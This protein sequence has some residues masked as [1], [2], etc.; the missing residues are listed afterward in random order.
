[1]LGAVYVML[2]LPAVIVSMMVRSTTLASGRSLETVH[3][4][5]STS[6]FTGVGKYLISISRSSYPSSWPPT[7]KGCASCVPLAGWLS[8]LEV[9]ELLLT[10]VTVLSLNLRTASM[11]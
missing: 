3:R 11:W 2:P 10:R 1:M 8:W 9:F 4:L 6:S 5:R 7:V